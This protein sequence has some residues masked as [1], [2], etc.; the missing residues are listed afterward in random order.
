MT[1]IYVGNLSFRATEDDLR[2]EFSQHGEVSSVNI[3][4]DRETGRSRGF[5][6]VEMPNADEAQAAIEATNGKEIAGRG[7][8]VNEARPRTDRPRGG[9]GGGRYGDRGGNRGYSR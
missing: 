8:T 7:V 9:G 3:I 2:D 4:T 1:N 5:A 6:F